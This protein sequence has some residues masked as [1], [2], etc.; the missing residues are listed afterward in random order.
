[1]LHLFCDKFLGVSRGTIYNVYKRYKVKKTQP[2]LM[3]V[4]KD[5]PRSGP[6]AL[7]EAITW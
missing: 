2:P 7:S 3:A 1:L 6:F 5:E 4:L